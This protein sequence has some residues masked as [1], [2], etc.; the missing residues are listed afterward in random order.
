[1]GRT[2]RAR[3]SPRQARSLPA[4]LR[5]FLTP[6]VWKRA[7]RAPIGPRPESRWNL[8]LVIPVVLAMTRSLGES[9]PERFEMARGIVAIGRPKRRRAGDTARG[10]QGAPGRLPMRPLVALAV[11]VRGRPLKRLGDDSVVDG[12]IPLGRDGSRLECA[13]DDESLARMG[14]AGTKDGAPSLRVTALAHL[15][16]GVPW[17]WR[18]GKGT[19]G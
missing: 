5:R 17:G 13:R 9:T 16:T 15:A 6:A 1:M 19:A 18:L 7:R 14:Q 4:C 2:S 3:R 11:A 12:F 10:L 8:H